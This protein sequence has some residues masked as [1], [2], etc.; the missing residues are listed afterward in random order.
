VKSEV[1][2]RNKDGSKHVIYSINGFSAKI[3]DELWTL[4]KMKY[5]YPMSVEI[6]KSLIL[7]N[8]ADD[9]CSFTL[10]MQVAFELC[11]L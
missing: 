6:N 10:G 9:L 5:H 11:S 4:Y 3:V 1:A 8:T 2:G 7:M